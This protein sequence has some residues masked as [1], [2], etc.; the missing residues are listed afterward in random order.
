[1][2][3]IGIKK[4]L[5]LRISAWLVLSG[6]WPIISSVTGNLKSSVVL[7]VVVARCGEGFVAFYFPRFLLLG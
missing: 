1:M 2:I 7:M 5:R 6:M 3:A 4:G